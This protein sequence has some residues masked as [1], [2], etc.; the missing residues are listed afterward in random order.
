MMLGSLLKAGEDYSFLEDEHGQLLNNIK[1]DQSRLLAYLPDH[2]RRHQQ[3]QQQQ[4]ATATPSD[5]TT[6]LLQRVT[7]NY[8]YGTTAQNPPV[9]IEQ[10]LRVIQQEYRSRPKKSVS[11]EVAG[12]VFDDD[13]VVQVL[14]FAALHRLPQEVT[15]ELLGTNH[16]PGSALETG[17]IAFQTSGWTGVSFP[18]GLAIRT[19]LKYASPAERRTLAWLPGGGGKRRAVLAQQAVDAAKRVRAPRQQLQTRREFLASMEAQLS[20]TASP[21]STCALER[22]K[23]DLLFFPNSQPLQGISFKRI[24]RAVDKNYATLKAQGRGGVVSYAFFNFLFYTIGILWQWNKVA[25]ALPTGSSS[26]WLLAMRKFGRIY[27]TLYVGS[28]VF[29]IP[30]LFASVGLAPIAERL[31]KFVMRKLKISENL[32]CILLLACLYIGWVGIMAVP[33]LAEFTK[34]KRLINLERLLNVYEAQ[35]ALLM[36]KYGTV[37]PLVTV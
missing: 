26:A 13:T 24:K 5:Q 28:Q 23:D 19:R 11:V 31:L 2:P 35:P 10:V 32:A 3:Q 27:G 34:L 7:V 37:V 17:K 1:D 20:A 15:I 18:D 12:R 9:P 29:K 14:S 22:N 16:E 21:L 6:A 36:L 8:M 4:G 30:K 25:S 33:F